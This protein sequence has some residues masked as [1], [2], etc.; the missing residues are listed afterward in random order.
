TPERRRRFWGWGWEGEGPAPEQQQA[1]ARLLAARFALSEVQIAE[2]PRLEEIELPPPRLRPPA[3]L[4][5]IFSEAPYDRAAHTHGKSFRDVVRAFRRDFAHPPDLVAF[6][7]S[8]DDARAVLDWAA[9]GGAAVIPYGGGSSVV[10][11]VEADV[12]DRYRGAVSLDLSRLDRVLEVDRTS[13]AARIQAGVLGPALEE[14]LRPHGLTLRHFPQSFEFSSLGGWVA[15]RSGG[16][17]ATL[18]THIDE[19]VESLRV[20]TPAGVVETRRLPGSGEEAVLLLAFEAADHELDAWMARAR[21]LA[22][23]HGGRVPPD[24]GRTRKAEEGARDGA[25]GAWRKSFLDAPYLRDALVAMGMI[26]ET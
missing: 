7:R 19:F 5:A 2:P 13:R 16:H 22:A 15:T 21:A 9:S 1:I 18:Y 17:Y 6:P 4:G 20:V 12:G 26:S 25:A 14:Q 10:G 23:A 3:K 24:A 8:E 11:G